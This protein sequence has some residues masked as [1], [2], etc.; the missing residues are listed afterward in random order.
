[1]PTRKPLSDAAAAFLRG[2]EPTA[3]APAP[4]SAQPAADAPSP[5]EAPAAEPSVRFTVDL[6]RSLHKR[7]KLAALNRD[8]PMTA[9]VREALAEWLGT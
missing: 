1:M 9:L 7:L 6:P 2:D 8:Q 5:P 4:V 3:A